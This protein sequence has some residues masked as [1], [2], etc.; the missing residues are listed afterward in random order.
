MCRSGIFE[1][2]A[3]NQHNAY[4]RGNEKEPVGGL[5][6]AGAV[7]QNAGDGAEQE[8]P[9][10]VGQR[11]AAHGGLVAR[12][13]AELLRPRHQRDRRH[14]QSHAQQRHRGGGKDQACA[15]AQAAQQHAAEQRAADDEVGAVSAQPVGQEAAENL[16]EDQR[17]AEIGHQPRDGRGRDAP[18]DEMDRQVAEARPSG[19]RQ[20]HNGQQHRAPLQASKGPFRLRGAGRGLR[21]LARGVGEHAQILRPVADE[22]QDEK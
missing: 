12:V 20:H 6:G 4:R 9:G 5:V 22:Q 15:S 2:Y 8:G 14:R 21:L 1:I 10:G 18:A 16:A 13:A 11:E 19:P 3:L 7:G 17:D